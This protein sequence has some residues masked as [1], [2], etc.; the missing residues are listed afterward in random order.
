M[1]LAMPIVAV[2]VARLSIGIRLGVG[3]GGEGLILRDGERSESGSGRVVR[4]RV[5]RIRR[6]WRRTLHLAT[7]SVRQCCQRIEPYGDRETHA[8]GVSASLGLVLVVLA[9]VSR[10]PAR[11]GTMDHV[12]ARFKERVPTSRKGIK[13]CPAPTR[14]CPH[15]LEDLRPPCTAVQGWNGPRETLLTL[16]NNLQ[17]SHFFHGFIWIMS[18]SSPD[19]LD[20][21]HR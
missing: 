16:S 17:R 13:V 14:R 12:K 7:A 9:L 4:A 3:S 1:R 6:W 21:E 20:A 19:T 10:G 15:H 11:A 18:V 2:V 5:G 8:G